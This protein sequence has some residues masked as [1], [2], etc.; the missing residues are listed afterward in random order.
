MVRAE[1]GELRVGRG[2]PRG[3]N[4]RAAGWTGAAVLALGFAG[5]ILIGTLLLLLPVATAAG[6]SAPPSVALFT[7]TSAVCVTGLA[8]VET[9]SY[10]SRFGQVVIMLLIELGGVGFGAGATMLFWLIGRNIS[11]N[12]R[13]MLREIVP[14]TNLDQVV[15]TSVAIVGVSVAIQAIGALI[16][17]AGWL[18]RYPVGEAAFLAL[19]HAISAFCNAGFDVF[20]TVGQPGISMGA[21]RHN[22]V[23]LMPITLLVLLGGL[24]FPVIGELAAWRPRRVRLQH[25]ATGRLP[26]PRPPLSLNARLVLVAH[27]GLFV[28]GIVAFWLLEFSNP[29]TFGSAAPG[30]QFLDA[31]NTSL[32]PRSVGFGSIPLDSFRSTSLLLLLVLMFVGTASAG[33]GGGVKVNTVAALFA[34][35]A[36]TVAGRPRPELFKR[37]LSQESIN[38]A[39]TVV[40]ISGI[41]IVGATLLLSLTDPALALTHALFEVVSAFST[42]GLT[43]DTTARLSEAG[44]VIIELMMFIGRLG[45]LTLVVLLAARERAPYVTYAEEPVLIG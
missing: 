1:F 30:S 20:G 42:V 28:F 40:L 12:D 3:E 13:R 19:F 5:L 45:P 33:T 25:P 2:L 39:L 4:R 21:E 31:V 24:G 34:G 11:L 7:A 14:G 38:K 18:P 17:F 37:T 10:W 41:V 32:Y 15:R 29:R 8:V 27:L 44:R 16:L 9:G 26:Q 6:M 36:G 23:I 22:P 35:A 43:M